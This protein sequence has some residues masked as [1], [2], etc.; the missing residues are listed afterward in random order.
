MLKLNKPSLIEPDLNNERT[1][2][3][4]GDIEELT[5]LGDVNPDDVLC[6][7]RKLQIWIVSSKNCTGELPTSSWESGTFRDGLGRSN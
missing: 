4:R 5:S 3:C 1:L 6:K 2:F 7:L